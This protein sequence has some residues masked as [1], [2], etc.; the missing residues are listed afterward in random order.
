MVDIGI[1]EECKASEWA[2]SLRMGLALLH[3]CQK[4]WLIQTNI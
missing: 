2:Q 3:Y 4:R 1:L